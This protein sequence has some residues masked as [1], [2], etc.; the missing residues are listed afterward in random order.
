MANIPYGG[1]MFIHT[2]SSSPVMGKW[3]QQSVP[4]DEAVNF[5]YRVNR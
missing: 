5:V 4:L 3:E 2:M 1:V